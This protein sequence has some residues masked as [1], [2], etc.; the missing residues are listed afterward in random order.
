MILQSGYY[1]VQQT[2]VKP[3]VYCNQNLVIR[4]KSILA[5]YFNTE[6]QTS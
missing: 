3:L 2:N 6:K 4:L 5:T 1:N